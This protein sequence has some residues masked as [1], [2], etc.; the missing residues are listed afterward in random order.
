[1]YHI[2]NI[3][4]EHFENKNG[5]YGSISS[6]PSSIMSFSINS[7]MNSLQKTESISFSDRSYF[8]RINNMI[9]K[10]SLSS[11]EM[12]LISISDLLSNNFFPVIRNV[13]LSGEALSK[14]S[15]TNYD[16]IYN[17]IG[18]LRDLALDFA[19]RF[20]IF[21][22]NFYISEGEMCE[23]LQLAFSFN[24]DLRIILDP[25][26]IINISSINPH[27][28]DT[29]SVLDDR[30]HEHFIGV[31]KRAKVYVFAPLNSYDEILNVLQ[32]AQLSYNRTLICKGEFKNLITDENL[33]FISKIS[34]VLDLNLRKLE[35]NKVRGIKN[36][37]IVSFKDEFLR[38]GDHFTV[39]LKVSKSILD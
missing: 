3:F 4:F 6:S 16:S 15:F 30:R 24:F 25:C 36:F 19:L 13:N 18:N 5:K 33:A 1:M 9:A 2:K 28:N 7:L 12:S 21:H 34:E 32:C 38:N 14:I 29:I 22:E 35:T 39:R 31:Q 17:K 26:N 11:H 8:A 20:L 27:L 37:Y 23:L 10:D